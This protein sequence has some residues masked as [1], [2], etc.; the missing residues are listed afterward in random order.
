MWLNS[1]Y[2]V[3]LGKLLLEKVCKE[4]NICTCWE[5][6]GWLWGMGRETAADTAHRPC[7]V[8]RGEDGAWLPI[9]RGATER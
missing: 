3:V 2:K 7:W 8:Q 1:N 4:V 9:M 5:R 6:S